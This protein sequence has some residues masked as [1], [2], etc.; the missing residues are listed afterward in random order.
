MK[1]LRQLFAKLRNFILQKRR[2]R[3]RSVGV[4]PAVLD[5]LTLYIVGQ[6]GHQ[7]HVVM[8]CPCG[9]ESTLFMNLLPDE[10]PCWKISQHADGTASLHPSIWRKI[11]CK[12]H[13]FLRHG[14]IQWCE[15][16]PE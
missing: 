5:E 9:C 14:L 10:D 16:T 13:F 4:L 1:W 6:N 8:V 3:P 7:W 11:G 15:E 2:I 12:S